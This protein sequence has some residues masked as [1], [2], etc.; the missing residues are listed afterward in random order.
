MIALDYLSKMGQWSIEGIWIPLL[1]WTVVALPA[2]LLVGARRGRAAHLKY[3]VAF[4]TLAALPCGLVAAQLIGLA[5]GTTQP[6]GLIV[7][8]AIFVGADAVVNTGFT[9]THAHTAGGLLI[10]AMAAATWR[11]GLLLTSYAQLRSLRE[12]LSFDDQ[13]GM[14][15]HVAYL[16]N[17]LAID[18]DIRV[19]VS[20]YTGTPMTFGRIRPVIVLPTELVE[21]PDDLRLALLHELIH[22]RRHD[23]VLQW[24]EQFVGAVFVIHP[25]VAIIRREASLLRETSCDADVVSVTGQKGRYARLLYNFSATRRSTWK[26][27]VGISLRENHL[28]KRIAAMKNFIDLSRLSSAKRIGLILGV[29]LFGISVTI[30]ACSEQIVGTESQSVDERLNNAAQD[31][32]TYVVVEDMPELVGGLQSIQANLV[33]PELAMKA[34]IEGRVIIQFVVDE[35]GEV[36]NPVVVRGIGSGLDAAALSAVESAKFVP[37]K[38]RGV[39]VKVKMS[40]PVTFKLPNESGDASSEAARQKVDGHADGDVTMP[41]VIGGLASIQH[42]MK[43]PQSARQDGIEGRVIVE[44]T[45]DKEGNV[46][47]V[48][49]VRGVNSV[50][51]KEALRVVEMARF[52]PGMIEGEPTEVKLSLPITFKLPNE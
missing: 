32:D 50:L 35:E 27:A 40:L 26:M 12:A 51:D 19:A 45:V 2:L 13:P 11:L 20:P 21:D 39:P 3:R 1:V 14:H 6:V 28:K 30:V 52:E 22:I 8:P 47:D 37:G 38:Q 17:E 18:R 15:E 48:H 7:L 42:E 29:V 46:R 44:F 34:G 43:Y 10:I 25:L 23:Y 36:Q 49:I 24:I 33:Y 9:W 5:S 4:A 31:A 41:E 16:A